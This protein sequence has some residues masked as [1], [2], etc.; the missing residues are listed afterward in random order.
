MP[1]AL[2]ALRLLPRNALS[3]ALGRLAALRL[4]RPLVRAEIALFAAA[5]GVD[6]S[7]M[8]EPPEAFASLQAFFIRELRPG[9]RPID[10]APDALVAPC[11]GAWGESGQ[12]VSGQLM[13]VKGRPYALAELLDSKD[14]A[15]RFE[16]GSFATFY[17]APRDYHR[18]HAPCDARVERAR[19]VPGTLWPVNRLGLTGIDGL[20]AQNERIAVMMRARANDS[21]LCLVAVGA[22]LVGKVRLRFDGLQTNLRAARGEERRYPAD[23]ALAKGEE[24]GHFE[25]GSSIV[26]VAAPGALELAGQPAGTRLR[27]GTRIGRLRV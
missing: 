22:T 11:D 9:V 8:R 25:F 21:L 20:Y 23:L 3:R 16:G 5:V 2:E 17:L 4:P 26:L 12:V 15:A 27:L 13:Q 24:W 6:L 18:F 1:L 7:E 19:Y 14:D 10:P